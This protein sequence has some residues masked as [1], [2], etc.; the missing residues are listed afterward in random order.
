MR[1]TGLDHVGFTVS[2]IERSVS[3]YAEFLGEQPLSKLDYT[4]DYLGRIAGYLGC[5]LKMPCSICHR[6]FWNS[7]NTFHPNPE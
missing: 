6:D 5:Q 2:E 1:F 4:A 7:S 3:W